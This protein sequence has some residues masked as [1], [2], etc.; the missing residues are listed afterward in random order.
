MGIRS[1]RIFHWVF[2]L[3]F[4]LLGLAVRRLVLR[5][6]RDLNAMKI[7]GRLIPQGA[8]PVVIYILFAIIFLFSGNTPTGHCGAL[9]ILPNRK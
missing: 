5:L 3:L 7:L 4:T 9:W 6:L 1:N 2:R 8:I